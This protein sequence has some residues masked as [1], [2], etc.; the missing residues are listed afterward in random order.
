LNFLFVNWFEHIGT[1]IIYGGPTLC[2]AEK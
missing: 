1:N 2:L